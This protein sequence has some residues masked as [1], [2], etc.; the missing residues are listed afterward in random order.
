[1]LRVR[2]GG[3]SVLKITKGL[4]ANWVDKI[5]H[6]GGT[7]GLL[8]GVSYITLFEIIE[9]LVIS[10]CMICCCRFKE[11]KVKISDN[12]KAK[13]S[14]ENTIED[15]KKKV[16]ENTQKFNAMERRMIVHD[17]TMIE[18]N[19]TFDAFKKE[20]DILKKN[21][22]EV[23]KKM[24]AI[25]NKMVATDNKIDA[26]DNKMVAID[27]KM[28]ATDNKINTMDNKM[29]AIDNKLMELMEKMMERKE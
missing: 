3:F 28:V 13:P 11:N 16:D 12:V 4:K 5:S 27:N 20:S 17:Y 2:F 21:M 19:E 14:N 29:D 18:D 9:I 26:I 23:D 7:A 6:F 15:L 22:D 25:S 1:M 24:D 10:F 8:T